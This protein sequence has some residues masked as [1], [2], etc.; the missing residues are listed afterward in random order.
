MERIQFVTFKGKKILVEDFTK[1]SP[2]AEFDQNLQKAQN[3]IAGEAANSVLAL[4]DATDCSFNTDMLNKMKEFTKANTP[5]IK[6]ATVV[7]ITGLL[8]VALSTVSKFSGRDFISYKTR[9]EAMEFL[10]GQA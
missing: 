3:M 6:K 5:F 7:G 1:L 8:Q 10:A 4:F 9:E 2:G